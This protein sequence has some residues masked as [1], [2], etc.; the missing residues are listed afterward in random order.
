[1]PSPSTRQAHCTALHSATESR[2]AKPPGGSR[3]RR[4]R[5]T[6]GGTKIVPN[7]CHDQMSGQREGRRQRYRYCQSLPASGIRRHGTDG[8]GQTVERRQHRGHDT[9]SDW[10]RC[11]FER[12]SGGGCCFPRSAGARFRPWGSRVVTLISLITWTAS[13]PTLA[14]S[15]KV[16]SWRIVMSIMSLRRKVTSRS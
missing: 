10:N 11:T 4:N 3:V 9:S 6:T 5:W 12:R 16:I 7:P 13:W 2:V 1:M 15:L 8:T 14:G